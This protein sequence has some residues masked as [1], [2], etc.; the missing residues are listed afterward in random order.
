[1][2]TKK[3]TSRPKIKESVRI[4]QR[5]MKC[6]GY[7]LL[8]D[9]YLNGNRQREFLKLYL[10]PANVPNAT[11]RN[12]QTLALAT[13]IKSRKI[14]EMQNEAHGF[15]NAKINSK[16][17]LLDYIDKVAEKRKER[18]IA[19][20]KTRHCS[21]FSLMNLRYHLEK[22]KGD[23]IT[24]QQVDK[25]F[26][27]G[28][29]EYLRTAKSTRLKDKK[30]VNLSPNTQLDYLNKLKTV[31]NDAIADDIIQISPLK[32]IRKEDKPKG[33]IP[34]IEYLTNQELNVLAGTPLEA[35]PMLKRAFLFSCYTGLR[36]TDISNLTWDCIRKNDNGR[37][38]LKFVQSKTSK[39]EYPPISE[40]AVRW[41]PERGTAMDND[42]IFKIPANSEANK[43]LRDWVKS[44]GINKRISYH[45]SRHTAATLL[46]SWGVP[47]TTVQKIM[48]HSDIRTTLR[49]AKVIDK[50][51]MDAVEILD[52]LPDAA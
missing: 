13:A 51:V 6:G 35:M 42:C 2:K 22:L 36:F 18:T 12:N 5:P 9:Y 48:G 49:Y 46:L 23:K 34:E 52:N 29:V 31:L 50:N 44:A 25:S 33:F 41:L 39:A 30:R 27:V 38:L 4:C 20:G 45:V 28:F 24:F 1:M 47:V 10:L 7:S 21:Y 43:H 19:K 11:E 40:K 32:K 26:C 16:T 14:T 3:I 37:T 15:S 17:N 8:L